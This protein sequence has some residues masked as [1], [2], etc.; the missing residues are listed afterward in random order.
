MAA[1]K[2]ADIRPQKEFSSA[3]ILTLA[4]ALFSLFAL[5]SVSAFAAEDDWAYTSSWL[6]LDLRLGS[7]ISL[8][9]KG[10]FPELSQVTAELT[11]QPIENER[12]TLTSFQSVPDAAQKNGNLFFTWND[13][14][15]PSTLP[16]YWKAKVR[17]EYGLVR[18]DEKVPFPLDPSEIEGME[19]YL[20]FT[21]NIDINEEIRDLAQELAEG[22]DDLYV[23]VFKVSEW[24]KEN[25]EYN[26]E[27]AESLEK[28]TTT[29]ETRQ[30][31]CDEFTALFVSILRSLGIPTKYVSGYAYTNL[32]TPA[33]FGP[34]A[35]AEVYFPTKGWV[36]FDVT[37][38][39]F[40]YIDASHVKL[41]DSFD[42][43]T[44][45]TRY[46]WRGRYVD[47]ESHPLD[48][49]A[50]VLKVGEP[51]DQRV[52]LKANFAKSEAGFGSYNLLEVEVTNLNNFYT[53]VTVYVT[54]SDLLDFPE[55]NTRD[56]LLK[57]YESKKL[58]WIVHLTAALDPNFQY[59]IPVRAYLAD[60][61]SSETTFTSTAREQV[62]SKPEIEKLRDFS[63]GKEERSF[64]QKLDL[65]CKITD[66]VILVKKEFTISCV[67]RNAGNVKLTDVPVCVDTDCQEVDLSIAESK[68]ITFPRE[69]MQAGERELYASASVD[70]EEESLLLLANVVDYPLIE[71]M[72]ITA[73]MDVAYDDKFRMEFLLHRESKSSPQQVQIALYQ[74]GVEVRIWDIPTL[75]NDRRFILDHGGWL[76]KEGTNNFVVR[77]TYFD[78]LAQSYSSEAAFTIRLTNVTFPQKAYLFAASVG[79]GKSSFDFL[80]LVLFAFAIGGIVGFVLKGIRRIRSRHHARHIKEHL[81]EEKEVTEVTI[82]HEESP[83]TGDS[84]SGK[85]Q[86]PKRMHE[87]TQ[88]VEEEKQ[89]EKEKP[90]EKHAGSKKV[91]KEESQ[92]VVESMKKNL[93]TNI[94]KKYKELEPKTKE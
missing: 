27:F 36:P 66:E 13:P 88:K 46:E 20:L 73:P 68:T 48:F 50:N 86:P 23:L 79:K 7:E 6:D 60:G 53:G 58:F 78:E 37:Y 71:I 80:V 76:L 3:T 42:S 24:L 83:D 57:P 67:V 4:L 12:Q 84:D 89:E 38:N 19:K 82:D 39:E 2:I 22:E 62:F 5:L 61:V 32:K 93:E 29:F 16:F 1:E 30:G 63:V 91:P 49:T 40:G 59:Q 51:N 17:T 65:N 64:S 35:W 9:A 41:K 70:G 75:T 14:V 85:L 11:F 28:P 90:Q 74:D 55:G 92:E 56:V 45:S 34:H 33:G 52:S 54:K 18:I 77:T 47:L 87:M 15:V 10:D 8:V 94:K 72:N 44:Y 69:I 81:M 26:L 31:V 21:E 25:I 43:G